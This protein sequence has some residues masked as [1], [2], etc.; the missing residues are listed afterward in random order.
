VRVSGD[1]TLGDRIVGNSIFLNTGQGIDLGADG[2]TD[3]DVDD[4]DA[5]ANLRQ[6]FPVIASAKAGRDGT[7]LK[8]RLNSTPGRTFTVQFFANP[9]ATDEGK[10]FLGQKT[11]TT[12]ADGEVPISF[13]T[14]KRAAGSVTATAT[15][16]A[17]NT[18]EFSAPKTVTRRR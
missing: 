4:P 9:P 6:N 17:G 11:V 15:D 13:R 12:D 2:R 7:I 16:P 18:S 14:R 1:L 5:G 10:T 8:G 3:N